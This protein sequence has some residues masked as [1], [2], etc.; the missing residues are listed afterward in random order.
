MKTSVYCRSLCWALASSLIVVS[1]GFAV[2]WVPFGSSEYAVIQQNLTWESARAAALALSEP[3]R[4]A[5]LVSITSAE[6]YAFIRATFVVA[7]SSFW[8]GGYQPPGSPEPAGGWTWVNGD[9][10]VFTAW[11][12]GEPNNA[13]NEYAITIGWSSPGWNDQNGASGYAPIVKR[14][15]VVDIASG[16]VA[17][18]NFEE[19][20]GTIIHDQSGNGHHGTAMGAFS[21]S[22]DAPPLASSSYAGSFQRVGYV[23]VPDHPALDPTVDFTLAAWIKPAAPQG[24]NYI[25]AKH[26]PGIN[27]DGSWTWGFANNLGHYFIATPWT[28]E[29]FGATSVSLNQWHHFVMTYVDLSDTYR[30]FVDGALVETGTYIVDIRDNQALLGIGGLG[31][32]GGIFNGLIDEVRIY[33][34]ALSASDVQA[35]SSSDCNGNQIPDVCE[36]DADADGHI[37]ACDNCPTVANA[38]QADSDGDG[39]GNACDNCLAAANPDQTDSDGD[40]RGDVCDNCPTVANADQADCDSDGLGDA[41]DSDD[42]NDGVADVDDVCPCNSPAIAVECHGRP[43]RDCNGDCK[44]NGLDLQCIIAELLG[45]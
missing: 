2:D 14:P 36:P 16:L 43:L 13:G 35:L 32:G 34:R 30:F 25:L 4:P 41:C 23:R 7:N 42:D 24:Y 28:G 9:P 40:G 12:V 8:T 44:V 33:A 21:F 19:G 3:G 29:L 38:D 20:S 22:G 27:S 6:E 31:A 11:D 10:F 45:E 17:Y 26:I 39:I 1:R 18:W 15:R 37:D 5:D